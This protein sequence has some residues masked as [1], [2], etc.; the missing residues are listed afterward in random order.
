MSIFVLPRNKQGVLMRDGGH[1]FPKLMD[2]P[3]KTGHVLRSILALK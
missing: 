1:Y 3:E 2:A